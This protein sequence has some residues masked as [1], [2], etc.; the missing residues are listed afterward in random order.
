MQFTEVLGAP[1]SYLDETMACKACTLLASAYRV[2]SAVS[3]SFLE[4][5]PMKFLKNVLSG[6]CFLSFVA[7]ASAGPVSQYYLTA[8]DEGTNWVVQGRSVVNDWAQQ[9]PDH[10]G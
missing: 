10:L 5:I 9:H 1:F 8:G 3:T 7:G 6:A 2:Y 4:A